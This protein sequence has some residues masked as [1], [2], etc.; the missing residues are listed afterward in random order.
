M[1]QV[2]VLLV[3]GNPNADPYE[4]EALY[5]RTAL[6]A[7]GEMG[8]DGGVISKLLPG[9][10][11]IRSLDVQEI[12]EPNLN[13]ELLKTASVVVLANCGQLNET[14]FAW[15]RQY[16]SSGGG[17]IIFPGDRVVPKQYNDV[18]FP[19]P[20]PQNERLSTVKFLPPVGEPKNTKGFN[21]LA[22]LDFQHPVLNVFDDPKAK[23]LATAIFY[24]H[25]PMNAGDGHGS[26]WP[27]AR[28]ASGSPALVESRLGEGVVLVAAFPVNV[29]WSNLPLKPEFVPLMLR[30]VSHVQR[31]PDLDT[32]AVAQ[33]GGAAEITAPANWAGVSGTVNDSQGRQTP[34]TFKRSG[35]RLVSLFE[36]P[37]EKGYYNVEVKGG[38][39]D[40]AKITSAI[41]AVN[42]SP[43][44]SNFKSASEDELR[45]LI[46]KAD[47]TMI[48]A[49]SQAQQ[50]YGG[51]GD[52]RE[53]WRPLIF[54]LFAIIAVEFTLATL[55]PQQGRE[56]EKRALP[57]WVTHVVPEAWL[58]WLDTK[59]LWQ[60]IMA[61]M[62]RRLK[63]G[64]K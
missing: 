43:E 50:S 42:V 1:P 23:Y 41:V 11:F 35:A 33:A 10:E 2:K 21:R 16:V 51:L 47:L 49:T 6:T 44:E 12:P 18:F 29:K 17:L 45:A 63:V 59:K 22:G 9:K 20:G 61:I 24:R 52:E 60:A 13:A 30:M 32:P 26:S 46:P 36:K 25:F 4:N 3:N 28:F 38:T 40:A 14:Q 57:G 39:T 48:D 64:G 7:S 27:L 15:L 34:L 56:D 55:N 5:L 37:R 8:D 31:R 54:V 62:P 53:I 19:V 58:P